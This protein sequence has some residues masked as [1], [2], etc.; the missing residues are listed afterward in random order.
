MLKE[1]AIAIAAQRVSDL[2]VAFFRLLPGWFAR[3]FQRSDIALDQIGDCSGS[4]VGCD[5]D[6]AAFSG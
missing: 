4:S 2:V 5:L 6:A 1:C 3:G